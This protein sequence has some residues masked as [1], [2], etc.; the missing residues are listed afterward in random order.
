[1]SSYL[2]YADIFPEQQ[3]IVIKNEAMALFIEGQLA[4]IFPDLVCILDPQTGSGLMSAELR[5]GQDLALVVAACHPRLRGAL[6]SDVA[7]RA[8][9]PARFGLPQFDNRPIAELWPRL[10]RY[11]RPRP[12]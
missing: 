10:D 12:A 2:K 4:T 3:Q 9:S 6:A 7:Q 1:L 5:E 11:S 8:F